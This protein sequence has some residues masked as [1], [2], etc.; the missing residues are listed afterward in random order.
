[1]LANAIAEAGSADVVVVAAAGNAGEDN[2]VDPTVPCALPA[3]NLICVAALNQNGTLASYSNRG[4]TS[5][6]VGAP[7]SLILSSKTDWGVPI[8]SEDFEAGARRLDAGAREQRV[9]RDHPRRGR[10]RHRRPR[11]APQSHCPANADTRL[12]KA[13]PVLLRRGARL[14]HMRFDLKSD[15]DP[16]DDFW[17]GAVTDEPEVWDTLRS[18]NH[19]PASSRRRRSRSRPWTAATTCAQPGRTELGRRGAGQRGLR[20]QPARALS[21]TRPTTT[22]SWPLPT[23]RSP[24]QAS[25]MSISSTSHGSSTTCSVWRRSCAPRIRTPRPSR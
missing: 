2:D 17:V 16:S 5:V 11:T 7:G 10:V 19:C 1:M 25:Y 20:G 4:V 22:R 8:L 14:L 6:D 23:S 15:V 18:W 21:V 13:T 12:A 3:E 9:G 24:L